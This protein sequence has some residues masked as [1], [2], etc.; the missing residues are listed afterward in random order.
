M[1][2][3]MWQT[4]KRQCEELDQLKARV[5]ALEERA[6]QAEPRPAIFQQSPPKQDTLGL[7]KHGRQ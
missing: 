2:L 1:S 6:K 4:I 5:E 7:P 3:L